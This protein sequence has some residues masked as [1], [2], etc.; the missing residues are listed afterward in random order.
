M[1][2]VASV[3]TA[4]KA[5]M[6]HK[7]AL[8]KHIQQHA[9]ISKP[10]SSIWK[11]YAI[12]AFSCLCQAQVWHPAI[13]RKVDD[14]IRGRIMCRY[15]SIRNIMRYYYSKYFIYKA[16][17]MAYMLPRVRYKFR[18]LIG[19]WHQLSLYTWSSE[20]WLTNLY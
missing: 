20:T 14:I 5:V 12:M 9:Q 19:R 18:N 8:H 2:V 3:I 16:F 11:S 4:V 1:T 17:F 15:I 6:Y 13:Q 7:G 10:H